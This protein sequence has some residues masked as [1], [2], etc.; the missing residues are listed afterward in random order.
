MKKIIIPMLLLFTLAGCEDTTHRIP[1]KKTPDVEIISDFNLQILEKKTNLDQILT[2]LEVNSIDDLEFKEYK[3]DGYSNTKGI[4]T[5]IFISLTGTECNVKSEI[6]EK[7]AVLEVN[8]EIMDVRLISTITKNPD[9]GFVRINQLNKNEQPIGNMLIE[10]DMDKEIA[11]FTWKGFNSKGCWNDCMVSELQAIEDGNW[12]KK[13]SFII[14]VPM[15]VLTLYAS[16]AWD[17]M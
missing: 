2:F 13:A 17:C 10:Y 5:K 3:Y 6:S 4:D 11:N 9:E 1:M 8:P 14:G 15:S 12:I 7:Y 16:C